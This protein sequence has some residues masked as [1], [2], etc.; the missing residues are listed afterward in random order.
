MASGKVKSEEGS[1]KR[2]EYLASL[3]DAFLQDFLKTATEDDRLGSIVAAARLAQL[4]A[5]LC[6]EFEANCNVLIDG[7][8]EQ[9]VA[10]QAAELVVDLANVNAR[11]CRAIMG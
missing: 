1:R 4:G 7:P 8:T 2:V 9:K 10:N 11:E 3:A 6:E 5:I